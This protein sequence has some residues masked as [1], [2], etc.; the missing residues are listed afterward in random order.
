MGAFQLV[1]QV[2]QRRDNRA[3]EKRKR[4]GSGMNYTS[5]S[6]LLSLNDG[7]ETTFEMHSSNRRP[8]SVCDIKV[9][10]SRG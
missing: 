3:A 8:I 9:L 4:T 7:F 6:I 10:V 2:Q 1:D 5:R